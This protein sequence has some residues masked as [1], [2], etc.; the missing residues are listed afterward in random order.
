V[1]LIEDIYLEQ[2]KPSVT[3]LTVDPWFRKWVIITRLRRYKAREAQKPDRHDAPDTIGGQ[4]E[5]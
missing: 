4:W 5:R 1:K 2:L 3:F